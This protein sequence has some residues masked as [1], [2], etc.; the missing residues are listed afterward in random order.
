MFM[1]TYLLR[2]TDICA[3]G[4]RPSGRSLT[5]K[6]GPDFS[7]PFYIV[8]TMLGVLLTFCLFLVGT[9]QSLAQSLD[10]D[11]PTLVLEEIDQGI[12]GET[13]VF[14]VT[15]EDEQALESVIL[16]HRFVGDD[17]YTDSAMLRVGSTKIFS[18]SVET[19]TE[20]PRDIEYY[21][22]AQDSGGN[23]AIKGFAFDPLV[24]DMV[25]DVIATAAVT[26]GSGIG[27][28][29]NRKILYGVLG[30]L[31]IGLLAS[32]G[33]GSSSGGGTTTQ[34]SPVNLEVNPLP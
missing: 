11:P 31:A 20:D 13:Q 25:A 7:M 15:A 18:A 16:Y 28:S 22:Q 34:T 21:V 14:T 5:I 3:N 26:S 1:K 8:R 24:R 2:D 29:R 10:V 9:T 17:S 12:I 6:S 23:K 32:Q 4:I 33:G 27:M 19:T 30:V